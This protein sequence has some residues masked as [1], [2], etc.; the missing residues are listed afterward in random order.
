MET[1]FYK[2]LKAFLKELIEVFPEDQEIKVVSTKIN[3]SMLEKDNK[4]I[5]KFYKSLFPLE[6]EI[7]N[8][9]DQ[10]FCVDPNQFWTPGSNELIL[11]SKI[12]FYY[13]QV[14]Q[15]NKNTIKSYIKVIY[16]LSELCQK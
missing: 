2:Q 13:N 10:F 6:K 16:K 7:I 5:T 12:V 11:F 15:N 14:N 9:S 3:L 4:L 1:E 8:E